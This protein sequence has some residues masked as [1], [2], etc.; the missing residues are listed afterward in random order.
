M[1]APRCPAVGGAQKGRPA[2]HLC[3]ALGSA[4]LWARGAGAVDW[5]LAAAG[6]QH[7]P[8]NV[9]QQRHPGT[10]DSPAAERFRHPALL[11]SGR[12][13]ALLSGISDCRAQQGI[14]TVRS[15]L[16]Q[17]S[18]PGGSMCRV[19]RLAERAHGPPAR[20][21]ERRHADRRRSATEPVLS[22]ALQLRPGLRCRL[23]GASGRAALAPLPALGWRPVHQLPDPPVR[24]RTPSLAD[25]R[26]AARCPPE[27]VRQAVALVAPD[28]SGGSR[29]QLAAFRSGCH[30]DGRAAAH[31]AF[32]PG[33]R[34]ASDNQGLKHPRDRAA[35]A[36]AK[37]YRAARTAGGRG[38]AQPGDERRHHPAHGF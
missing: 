15:R 32:R 7:Q 14:A 31:A 24:C 8:A 12:V 17:R 11:P 5:R 13:G 6:V 34:N 21:A 35:A 30:R 20:A 9:C 23:R 28:A 16:A 27:E 10:A 18:E 19:R 4:A 25:L 1:A 37:P 29:R 3:R 2:A 22:G 38:P 33:P 36:R 26:L